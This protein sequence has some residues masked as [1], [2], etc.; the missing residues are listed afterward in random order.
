MKL[1]G[2]TFLRNAEEL[3]FPYIQSIQSILPICDE[4]VIALGGSQD[5]SPAIL[6]QLA[7]EHPKIKI[8]DTVWNEHMQE[9]LGVL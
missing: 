4:F 8:I 2:F 9:I 6:H 3:C 7:Q 5:N 1:S